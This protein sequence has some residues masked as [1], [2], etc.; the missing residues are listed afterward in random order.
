M[1]SKEFINEYNTKKQLSPSELAA[2]QRA[3]QIV[4]QH[5]A[6]FDRLKDA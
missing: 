2:I 5:Q 3:K 1:K 6:L 4:K